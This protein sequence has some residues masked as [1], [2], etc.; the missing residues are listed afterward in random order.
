MPIL[1]CHDYVE[2]ICSEINTFLEGQG[3][4]ANGI[5]FPIKRD[6]P[7]VVVKISFSN[8]RH[9]IQQSDL[10]ID[11]ELKDINKHLWKQKGGSIFLGKS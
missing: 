4:F 3:L 7:L 10:N 5:I 8:E 9:R 6:L 2:Q 1:S 11:N